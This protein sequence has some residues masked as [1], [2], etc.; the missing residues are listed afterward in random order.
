MRRWWGRDRGH[1][2]RGVDARP[3][4]EDAGSPGVH[5]P[6]LHN[7]LP[8]VV[9]RSPWRWRRAAALA[10]GW[11]MVTGGGVLAIAAI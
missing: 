8:R 10:A 1:G 6:H 3:G 11:S 5:G 2:L 4:S 9:R 7:A